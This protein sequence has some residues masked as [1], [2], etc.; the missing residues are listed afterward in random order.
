MFESYPTW[1]SLVPGFVLLGIVLCSSA[2][3]H[4]RNKHKKH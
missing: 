2:A 1:I 4:Y 3:F